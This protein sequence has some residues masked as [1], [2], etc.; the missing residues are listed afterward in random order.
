MI[1]CKW[2]KSFFT[3]VE[4]SEKFQY[5]FFVKAH[6][7]DILLIIWEY[8]TLFNYPS[9][10]SLKEGIKKNNIY[11]YICKHLRLALPTSIQ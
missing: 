10:I 11:I 5:F 4:E 3:N 8:T 6:R 2:K 7:K 9:G 1:Y